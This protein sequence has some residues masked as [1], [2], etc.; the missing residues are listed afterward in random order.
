MTSYFYYAMTLTDNRRAAL[1]PISGQ[2]WHR[3]SP[4]EEAIDNFLA[5]VIYPAITMNSISDDLSN[6]RLVIIDHIR[7]GIS[8]N[9][10]LGFLVSES[11]LEKRNGYCGVL[12][13]QY[14]DAY[15]RTYGWQMNMGCDVLEPVRVG[16]VNEDM[17]Q[18]DLGYVGRLLPLYTADMWV[19]PWEDVPNPD[20][21]KAKV[22]IPKIKAKDMNA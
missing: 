15:T 18:F 13:L 10:F 12:N 19:F 4:T 7:T 16:T 5:T 20:E 8:V 22:M 9:Q 17:E 11:I 3:S 2:P 14:S 21:E 1:V 6:H